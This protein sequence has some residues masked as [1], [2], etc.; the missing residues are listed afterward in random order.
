M[1]K[2]IRTTNTINELKPEYVN[3]ISGGICNCYC[4]YNAVTHWHHKDKTIRVSG[5]KGPVSD[6]SVCASLCTTLSNGMFEKCDLINDVL[7]INGGITGQLPSFF[8]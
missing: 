3:L 7:F 5:L 6:A 2:I 1:Y 4:S 8:K